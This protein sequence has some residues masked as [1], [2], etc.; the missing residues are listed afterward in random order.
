ME[1]AG[2]VEAEA[3]GQ[4]SSPDAAP[5]ATEPIT[6]TTATTSTSVTITATEDSSDMSKPRRP[7]SAVM[8]TSSESPRVQEEIKRRREANR[9]KKELAGQHSRSVELKASTIRQHYY[10]EGGFGWVVLGAACVVHALTSGFQFCFG[11]FAGHLRGQAF[12][13]AGRDMQTGKF[14][15]AIYE[16]IKSERKTRI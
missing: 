10:P 3:G 15:S 11:L 12:V 16:A 6:D 9:R 7:V 4:P 5:S 13:G 8:S 14:S 2:K 1:E